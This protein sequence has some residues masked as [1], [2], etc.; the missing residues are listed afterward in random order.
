MEL[1][2]DLG[3]ISLKKP[4][5]RLLKSV[6]T[7]P[8]INNSFLFGNFSKNKQLDFS[9]FLL[10]KMGCDFR[11]ARLDISEHPF[12]I[13]FH[14]TDV[15]L[16]TAIQQ[17]SLMYN[18]FSTIHEGGHGLYDL[19][20]PKKLF[21]SPICEP[22]SVGIHES[23]SRLWETCLGHGLP[24]WQYFFPILKEKFPKLK[25]VSLKQFYAGINKV[26]PGPV[27]VEADEVT[28][29]LHIIIRFEIEKALIEGSLSPKDVPEVWNDK[30]RQYLNVDIKNDSKGC[31]QDIHWSLGYF[32]YFPTYTLGNLFAAQLFT[33]IKKQT[34]DWEKTILKGD[35]LFLK[36][37]LHKNIYQYGKRY[38]SK[39]L[40][41]KATGQNLTS[42]YFV[43]YLQDK[44]RGI[45]K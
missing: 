45:Y 12:T 11:Y 18:I 32:G 24:F 43:K 38:S 37:W 36:E 34:P 4:L 8:E 2:F 41:K 10:E 14:P 21:G 3:P 16:T 17:S 5:I 39:A 23:Q 28:Y 25:N 7:K 6:E 1:I 15:R 22:V 40:I 42:K 35:L 19:G 31:L 27:R 33:T 26:N 13:N 9:K 29:N 44:Y 20:L 30:M